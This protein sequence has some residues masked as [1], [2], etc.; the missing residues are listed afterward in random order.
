MAG[1][2]RT[3][4]AQSQS[5]SMSTRQLSRAA[6][7]TQPPSASD[8]LSGRLSH[9]STAN[10]DELAADRRRQKRATAAA[11]DT[12]HLSQQPGD[13]TT[14]CDDVTTVR[15]DVTSSCVDD[16]ACECV[17]T[18]T[19]FIRPPYLVMSFRLFSSAT[20]ELTEL[21][22]TKLC[23]ML[24][25]QADLKMRVQNLGVPFPKN[26]DPKLLIFGRFQQL[27]I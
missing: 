20:P 8:E 18:D 26:W 6:I 4:Y 16:C 9:I 12:G 10:V 19:Q 1:A 7:D 11:N 14:V 23:H 3:A 25:S 15:D 21:N 13:V 5:P 24:G 22:S 17:V 27:C 2:F